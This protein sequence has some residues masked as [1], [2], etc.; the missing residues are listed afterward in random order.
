[1][2]AGLL[3]A[4]L[5]LVAIAQ[6]KK[7]ELRC[8]KSELSIRWPSYESNSEYYICPRLFAKPMTVTCNP[9]EVFTFVLQSC[10]APNRYIPAPA[11]EDLPLAAPIPSKPNKDGFLTPLEIANIPHPPIFNPLKPSPVV[12]MPALQ[13]AVLPF[14][15]P[16]PPVAAV[17]TPKHEEIK[18]VQKEEQVVAVVEEAPKPLA[19]LPPTPAPTPPVV[20][21]ESSKK[22]SVAAGKKP[23]TNKKKSSAKP[24]KNGK[25]PKTD[26]D[27]KKTAKKPKAPAKKSPKA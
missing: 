14:E 26:K 24:S 10:T 3:L 7:Y 17:E 2:K 18:P 8:A 27:S 9:G 25:K 4:T 23:T 6:A 19:P 16:K 11:V 21:N 5:S 20:A 12:E 1:M 15:I 13:P 22:P